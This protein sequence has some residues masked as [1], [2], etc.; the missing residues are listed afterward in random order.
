MSKQVYHESE[1]HISDQDLAF[2]EFQF[3]YGVG[4]IPQ[5]YDHR[6]ATDAGGAGNSRSLGG[7]G[8][9]CRLAS[10]QPAGG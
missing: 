6:E 4:A 8:T 10:S 9:A 2:L 1:T 3:H 5:Q 7:G